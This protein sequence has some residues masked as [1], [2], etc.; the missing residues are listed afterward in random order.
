MKPRR[1]AQIIL[2]LLTYLLI[3]AIFTACAPMRKVK[4]SSTTD[5]AAKTE[6][7]TTR[8]VDTLIRIPASTVTGSKPLDNLIK[9]DSLVTENAQVRVAVKIDAATGNVTATGTVK[10]V[11]VPVK[12]DERREERNEVAVTKKEESKEKE[13]DAGFLWGWSMVLLLIFLLGLCLEYIRRRVMG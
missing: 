7:I 6:I 9:G 5:S 12:V 8:K 4:T 11:E 1:I 10:P 2:I 3:M 13:P